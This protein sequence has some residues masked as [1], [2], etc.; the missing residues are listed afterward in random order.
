[1]AKGQGSAS[2]IFLLSFFSM[3]FCPGQCQLPLGHL[4]TPTISANSL[5][6]KVK[7]MQSTDKA[8][9]NKSCASQMR[10]ASVLANLK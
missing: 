4:F 1:M 2:V 3:L 5:S 6:H 10:R 8:M 7:I 9:K